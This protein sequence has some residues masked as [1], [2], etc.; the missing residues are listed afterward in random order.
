MPSFV[1]AELQAIAD[2]N[3]RM[4]RARGRRGLDILNKLRSHP[5][6]DFQIYDRE[7]PEFTGQPVDMK[8]VILAKHLDGKIITATLT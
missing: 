8:L 6:V 3:D 1:L 2:S 4:R 5:K 7:L